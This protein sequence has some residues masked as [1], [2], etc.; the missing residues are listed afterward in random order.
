MDLEEYPSAPF[1]PGVEASAG[2][3]LTFPRCTYVGAISVHSFIPDK[4]AR[5]WDPA[6]GLARGSCSPRGSCPPAV[7]SGSS[8]SRA[9]QPGEQKPPLPPR[10]A[11]DPE[12]KVHVPL[13]SSLFVLSLAFLFSC[14]SM[15]SSAALSLLSMSLFC[16][17]EVAI[18][19]SEA[20]LQPRGSPSHPLCFER[21]YLL[22][23]VFGSVKLY[24]VC[25]KPSYFA[26]QFIA[27][28][29]DISYS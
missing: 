28:S 12:Q 25:C 10:G 21:V 16:T 1:P 24:G 23:L 17:K 11:E 29:A 22:F 18:N 13:R 3:R 9:A 8:R 2:A 5:C 15:E 27:P 19:C 6:P 14:S 20:A 7:G 26:L 4:P